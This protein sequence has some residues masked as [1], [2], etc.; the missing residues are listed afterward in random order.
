MGVGESPLL[1][2]LEGKRMEMVKVK[3]LETELM[4]VEKGFKYVVRVVF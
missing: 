3:S 2:H 1:L 4:I